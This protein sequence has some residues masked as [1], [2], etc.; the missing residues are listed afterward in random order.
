MRAGAGADDQRLFTAPSFAGSEL[1][2]VQDGALER[3]EAG[4]LGPDRNGRYAGREHY[5]A[6]PYLAGRTVVALQ[7]QC[8]TPTGIVVGACSECCAGPDVEFHRL[9]IELEP[10]GQFVL[11]DINRPRLGKRQVGEVID[12]HLVV[13][14]Q[15]VI[16]LAPIVADTRMPVDNE[17]VDAK[18]TKARGEGEPGLSRAHDHA[19]GIAI[20][21]GLRFAAAVEP[22]VATE[23]ARIVIARR[24]QCHGH[25]GDVRQVVQH[26]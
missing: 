18:S 25:A 12:E 14:R 9:G 10:V 17:R 4:E 16:A 11:G 26:C 8:P 15:R 5:V 22:V 6:R 21:K 7:R 20:I 1:A 2:G 24:P 23:R 3:V 13:Q 19:C